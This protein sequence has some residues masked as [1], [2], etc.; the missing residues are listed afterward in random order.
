MRY[1]LNFSGT[2]FFYPLKIN[3]TQFPDGFCHKFYVFLNLSLHGEEDSVSRKLICI[4]GV[5][6]KFKPAAIL[7]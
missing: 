5:Q 7:T 1:C 6:Y 2:K 3:N 4:H